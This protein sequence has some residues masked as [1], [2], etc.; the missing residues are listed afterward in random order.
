MIIELI[1]ITAAVLWLTNL[2]PTAYA[3]HYSIIETFQLMTHELS[4]G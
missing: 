3:L 2:E 4:S 1:V